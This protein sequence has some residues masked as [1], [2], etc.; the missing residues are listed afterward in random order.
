MFK[1]RWFI[2]LFILFLLFFWFINFSYS[3]S[4]EY[5]NKIN[6]CIDYNTKWKTREIDDF[7]CRVWT[8]EQV[9]FQVILDLE[10]QKIDEKMDEYVDSLEK[11]KNRYY[12][13][14]LTYIDWINDINK[15]KE[16]FRKQYLYLCWNI[17]DDTIKWKA[18]ICSDELKLSIDNIQDF[19]SN[20]WSDCRKLVDMKMKIFD[21]VSYWLLMLNK[22]QIN[23]DDK[24]KYDQWQ[25][26]NYDKLLDIM[27]INL[28]Y[29]ERIWQ[30][31]PS[32]VAN[33]LK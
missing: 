5:K 23:S 12:S 14:N 2:N 20:Q 32:L 10:F 11:E 31:I 27:M 16:F 19:F 8:K 9:M 30:K 7:V 6:K 28:W 18:L 17:S 29:I 26:K 3:D 13:K 4:C 15:N 1:F 25:R 21:D 24:K 22:L 33:P